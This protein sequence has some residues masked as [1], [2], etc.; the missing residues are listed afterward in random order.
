MVSQANSRP[1]INFFLIAKQN[2][3]SELYRVQRCLHSRK[4]HVL[5]LVDDDTAASQESSPLLS[6]QSLVARTQ[7]F[8]GVKPP[9]LTEKLPQ[10]IDSD[11]VYSEMTMEDFYKRITVTPVN[12]NKAAFFWDL[13]V[14]PFPDCSDPDMI[15]GKIKKAI[16]DRGCVGELSIWAYV[17]DRNGSSSC[18]GNCLS[19]KTWKSRIYFLPGGASILNRMLNDIHLWAL[20]SP[21]DEPE[22]HSANLVV[23][24]DK[25]RENVLFSF[26][27]KTFHDAD[28]HV[29]LATPSQGGNNTEDPDWPGL[30][31]DEGLTFGPCESEI[32]EPAAKKHKETHEGSG[33]R[34]CP[35]GMFIGRNSN[36]FLVNILVINSN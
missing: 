11:D 25:V 33:P 7:F 4:H 5:V 12:G 36:E 18:S 32:L 15:Y 9:R 1:P 21:R 20:D 35:K 8:G 17:D 10:S 30:L 23:V 2:T 13:S 14:C 3:D 26:I 6:V 24:S 22:P 27:T 29:L 34:A 28:F 19:N 31:I 16:V